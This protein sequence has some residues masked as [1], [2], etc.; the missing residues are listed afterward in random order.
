MLAAC[1]QRAIGLA[2]VTARRDPPEG[3]PLRGF[4]KRTEVC[5]SVTALAKRMNDHER[6]AEYRRRAEDARRE[7]R[8]VMDLEVRSGFVRVAEE[9]E[10]MADVVLSAKRSPFTA[11]IL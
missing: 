3:P 8:C 2:G 11:P 10:R 1:Q 4:F 9:Y 6:A 7:A 5:A